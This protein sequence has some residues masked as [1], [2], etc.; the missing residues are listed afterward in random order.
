MCKDKV[1]VGKSVKSE[2]QRATL[3]ILLK[4]HL[5]ILRTLPTHGLSDTRTFN[6]FLHFICVIKFNFVLMRYQFF[7]IAVLGLGFFTRVN[8]QE[9]FMVRG[10]VSK[11]AASIER[12]AQVYI[13]NLRSRENAM[14]DDLGWFSIKAAIGDTLLFSKLNF[15]DQKVVITSKSDLPVYMQ[16][17]IQLDQV[18]IKGQTKKQ[19]LNEVMEGYRKQGIYY[20]G[21]PPVLSYFTNPINGLYSLFGTGPAR[22]RHFA[23][24][25]KSELEYSEVKRRY[26]LPVVMRVLSTD[27]TTAKHFM[28]Y[29]TPSYEDIK[30]WND[31]ELFQH[32]RK[33]YDF[34]DKS[35]NK[36]QLEQFNQ[37]TFI[38]KDTANR[39]PIQE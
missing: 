31:Y 10:V 9:T 39:R 34:Y 26:N 29:Y 23:E 37:P 17:V 4:N 36:K 24:V 33:S 11:S 3:R 38:K 18:T 2:R 32:I 7:L 15:T 28:E 5:S 20:N 21:K 25:S 12:V 19:E 27:S 35:D 8:A 14:S 16:A 1:L 13:T 6:T 30:K 22:A